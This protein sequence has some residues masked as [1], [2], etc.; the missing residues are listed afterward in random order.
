ML[1]LLCISKPFN[2]F[3]YYFILLW[4]M[5][6]IY[7]T[8]FFP[9]CYGNLFDITFVDDFLLLYSDHTLFI[10]G[11]SLQTNAILFI[12]VH[13]ILRGRGSGYASDIL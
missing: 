11:N 5:I 1:F 8:L 12:H 7:A 9:R 4:D 13:L 6:C 2:F 10:T 3:K